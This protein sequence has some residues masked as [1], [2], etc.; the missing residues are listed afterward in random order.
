MPAPLKDPLPSEQMVGVLA[1]C[2]REGLAF[3]EAWVRA[4]GTRQQRGV[5]RFQHATEARRGWR[6]AFEATREEW[7]AAYYRQDSSLS[8]ALAQ[9]VDGVLGRE[10]VSREVRPV[11]RE[12]V[13]A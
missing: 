8:R 13:A 12:L 4:L 3:D 6:E 7:R 11:A 10:D 9:V 2:R 1:Q 5:I